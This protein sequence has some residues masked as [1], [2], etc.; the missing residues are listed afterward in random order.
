MAIQK[1]SYSALMPP[2]WI[3]GLFH[4][5]SRKKKKNPQS[6]HAYSKQNHFIE[7]KQN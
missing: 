7:S 5:F 3:I 2:P 1:I 6:K 4:G